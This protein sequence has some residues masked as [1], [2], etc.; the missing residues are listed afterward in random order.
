MPSGQGMMTIATGRPPKSALSN[1]SLLARATRADLKRLT[2]ER[3]LRAR[4]INGL[5]QTDAANRFGYKTPAQLSQ[6]ELG[7]RMVPMEKL[8]RASSI[9]RVSLDFL[10]GVSAEPDRDPQAAHA[11]RV[12]DG[13]RELM[14]NMS[15]E[16]AET[17]I[18]QTKL[19]GPTVEASVIMVAE[20]ERVMQAFKRFVELNPKAFQNNMRGSATL[21]SSMDSFENNGLNVARDMIQRYQRIGPHAVRVSL[22]KLRATDERTR[23]LFE[24]SDA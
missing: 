7:R 23:H 12:L 16:L 9:Y 6:W 1:H 10:M 14:E 8:L 2:A 17:V 21:A 22:K 5:S 24:P 19:G 3:L 20:G 18:A 15:R 4:E 13:A 11:L